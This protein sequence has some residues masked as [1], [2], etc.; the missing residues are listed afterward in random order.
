MN[1]DTLFY[2]SNYVLTTLT[3]LYVFNFYKSLKNIDFMTIVRVF[4]V[5]NKIQ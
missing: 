2:L 4:V 3:F 1:N 5:R